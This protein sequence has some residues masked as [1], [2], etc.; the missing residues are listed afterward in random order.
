MPQTIDPSGPACA[1]AI[2]VGDSLLRE[3]LGPLQVH[4]GANLADLLHARVALTGQ[5]AHLILLSLSS[6]AE[7]TDL[8]QAKLKL[9]QEISALKEKP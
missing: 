2:R 8:I 6:A 4:A 1:E 9:Q 7:E 3:L 5:S